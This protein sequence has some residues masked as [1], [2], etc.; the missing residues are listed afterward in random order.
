MTLEQE[1][2][3]T[4]AAAG[5][6]AGPGEHAVAV[7]AAE[8]QSGTRVYVVAF[9]SGGELGYVALDAAGAAVSDRRLIKDAVTLAAL[10]ERAEEVSGATAAEELAERFGA[11]A[12]TLRA[13]GATVA[14][15]AADAVVATAGRLSAAAAGPR[16]ATPQFL[17]ALAPLAAE[18]ASVLD[19]F[20]PYAEAAGRPEP[21]AETP[22]D[23]VAPPAEVAWAALAA[24]ARAGDPANFASAMTAASG[25]VDAL[26][27]DVLGHY[28]VELSAE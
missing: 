10:A 2:E 6:H 24:A 13:A 11:A 22:A 3:T 18:L 9:E 8:P 17:D 20:V 27:A 15:D 1:L 14:A 5:R 19:A 21:G 26:V 28:R 23:A 16:A 7:I 25:A 4:L 12:R